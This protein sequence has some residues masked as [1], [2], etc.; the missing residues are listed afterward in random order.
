MLFNRW[1]TASAMDIQ[2]EIF[3]QEAIP[4]SI[5]KFN[6]K[7]IGIC[8][9]EMDTKRKW[10]DMGAEKYRERREAG[11]TAFPKPTH[12]E[13]A[14]TIDIPS[15]EEG[16][17]I[18]LRYFV[19][20]GEIRGLYLHIHGGGWVLSNNSAQDPYLSRMALEANLLTASV[21]YR[22]A[23]E[24]P[25]P[26]AEQDCYDAAQHLLSAESVFSQKLNGSKQVFLG[27]ESAGA[28]L[29]AST[30]IA[31]KERT[32]QSVT[33]VIL[34]YGVFD[35]GLTPSARN[36]VVP[37]VLCARDMEEYLKAYLPD[38]CHSLKALQSPEHS[39]LYADLRGLCPALFSCGTVDCLLVSH[40]VSAVIAHLLG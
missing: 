40:R 15:R 1:S 22:L 37:L 10:Y 16:R 9:D 21:E 29:A 14:E 35:L 34:N 12:L 31:L 36:S 13:K 3:A 20:E 30:V 18:P 39:P 32:Q 38:K 24:H 33:G 26:A 4:D 6:E 28:H 25:S 5:N 2:P 17:S 7:L 11:L 19:P 27:G 23:P 8:Q